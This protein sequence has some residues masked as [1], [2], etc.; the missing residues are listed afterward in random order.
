MA[1]RKKDEDSFFFAYLLLRMDFGGTFP[2]SLT[3]DSTYML[4]YVIDYGYCEEH[5]LDVGS[6]ELFKTLLYV[7]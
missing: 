5:D 6:S 2:T 7:K 4:R 3:G 1:H